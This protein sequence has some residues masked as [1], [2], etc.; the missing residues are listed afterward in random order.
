M[1]SNGKVLDRAMKGKLQKAKHTRI[2]E[3]MFM[4]NHG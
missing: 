1:D 2:Y 4:K 3:K